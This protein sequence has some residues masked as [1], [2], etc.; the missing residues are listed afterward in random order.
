MVVILSPPIVDG[1]QL[2]IVINF[3]G[4]TDQWKRAKHGHFYDPM[5][6]HMYSP[7]SYNVFHGQ[8]TMNNTIWNNTKIGMKPSKNKKYKWS[9]KRIKTRYFVRVATEGLFLEGISSRPST[10]WIGRIRISCCCCLVCVGLHMLL[11]DLFSYVD[12]RF[13]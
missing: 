6:S 7:L 4:W 2:E 9:Q 13:F 11:L 1:C 8:H 5:Y 3:W 12:V 10:L